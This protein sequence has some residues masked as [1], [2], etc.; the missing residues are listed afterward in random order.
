MSPRGATF[1]AV[2]D[3]LSIDAKRT[4]THGGFAT[5]SSYPLRA[6]VFSRLLSSR[7]EEMIRRAANTPVGESSSRPG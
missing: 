1:N 7:D 2:F 4:R 6:V 5:D 3:N